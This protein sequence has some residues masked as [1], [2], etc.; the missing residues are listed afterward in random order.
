MDIG[1]LI[2]SGVSFSRDHTFWAVLIALVFG[3]LAYWKPTG[4]FRVAAACLALGAIIYVL[5][6]LVD[7]TSEG[8]DKA[9]KFTATPDVKV[10]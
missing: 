2:A 1:D 10:D 8:I 3:A 9:Q 6:F 7:L 4:T 5:S